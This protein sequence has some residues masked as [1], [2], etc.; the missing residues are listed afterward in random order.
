MSAKI[1]RFSNPAGTPAWDTRAL[2]EALVAY[3]DD[4][5]ITK[6]LNGTITSWNPGAESIFGYTLDEVIGK[7]ILFLIP[8]ELKTEEEVILGKVRSGE[9]IRHYET[10]RLAKNGRRVA[11]SLTISPIKD[12]QG[13]I[14]GASKIA[15]DITEIK[16]ARE[17]VRR[18][19][20]FYRQ[21]IGNIADGLAIYD[22][23][24]LPIY[25]NKAFASIFGIGS[26]WID[27]H[28]IENFVAPDYLDEFKARKQR[29]LSGQ[30][31]FETME[32]RG[33]RYD[34]TLI[35]LEVGMTAVAIGVDAPVFQVIVHD[36]TERMDTEEKLKHSEMV[37]R[38]IVTN[39]PGAIVT[40]IDKETQQYVMA[41]GEGIATSGVTQADFL[42]HVGVDKYGQDVKARTKP[43]RAAAFEGNEVVVELRIAG[44]LWRVKYI[45]LREQDGAIRSIMTVSIDIT[46]IKQAEMDIKELNESLEKKVAERT[47]QLEVANSELEA[48]SYSV[49]HDLRAPLRIINGYADIILA[50]Y[51]A[52]LDDEGKRMFGLIMKNTRRMGRLIDELLNLAYIG[53][54][55]MQFKSAN[56]GA[57]VAG[58]V[59]ELDSLT[60]RGADI[61]VA[62][63]PETYCDPILLRQVWFNLLSNAVKYSSTVEIQQI[64]VGFED[65]GDEVVFYVQDHGVGFDMQYAHKLFGVFQRLHKKNEFEGIGVGLAL[66]KRIVGRHHGAIWAQSKLG[67]G[68]TFYFK[69]PKSIPL[70]TSKE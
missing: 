58:I 35:W 50:D 46:E 40:I 14:I 66:A 13:N 6:D 25:T 70:W 65:A 19:E 7:S 60:G 28:G 24:D 51:A 27:R 21:V 22:R 2:C 52:A 41:E 16:Q 5:I 56:I 47:R 17:A 49:S 36:I 62:Q 39:L 31:A 57:I 68:T 44:R 9:R 38:K 29:V 26:L 10:V 11:I 23:S 32:C 12:H 59:D 20:L 3:S 33:S 8:D 45:P 42:G 63:L 48:F 43:F 34:G 30:S 69:L 55:E 67:E 53:R 4:A 37:Y 61:H 64:N 15:R 1:N 18:N 54:R